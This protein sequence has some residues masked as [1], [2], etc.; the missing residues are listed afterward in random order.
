MAT[1]VMA[2]SRKSSYRHTGTFCDI[3]TTFRW[4]PDVR[5]SADNGTIQF[6]AGQIDPG[7]QRDAFL[8]TP[9]GRTA[10][11]SLENANWTNYKVRP[12]AGVVATLLFDGA[13]LDRV[14]MMMEIPADESEAWTQD[15][16]LK[17]KQ[18]HDQWLKAEF[19]SGPYDYSWGR[20]VSEFDQRDCA[21]EII[22]VYCR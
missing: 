14:F 9:L 13:R 22:V 19:G 3:L 17:R 15:L 1:L 20:I 4:G 11:L 5:I 6:A 21:S 10:T 12:E 2:G 8:A 7:Q 16:E 18:V